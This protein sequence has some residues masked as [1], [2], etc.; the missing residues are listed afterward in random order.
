[1][2]GYL[3]FLNLFVGVVISTFNAE[4]DKLSGVEFLTEQQKEWIQMKLLVFKRTGAQSRVREPRD[5][6][7]KL[8][9]RL[10]SHIAFDRT[11]VFLV[12]LNMLVLCVKWYEEPSQ[13]S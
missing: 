9:F 8:L 4:N 11:I 2:I 3:F 12:I 1:M 5:P 7:R 6:T 13:V 10:Q